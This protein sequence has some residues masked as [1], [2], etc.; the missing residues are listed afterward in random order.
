MGDAVFFSLHFLGDVLY[1]HTDMKEHLYNVN[2]ENSDMGC[3][4][5]LLVHNQEP[6]LGISRNVRVM[7]PHVTVNR[8]ASNMYKQKQ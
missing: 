2:D 6:V 7:K 1:L 5:M 3:I 8:R 4:S